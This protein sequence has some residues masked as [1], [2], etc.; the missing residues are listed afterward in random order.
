MCADDG[1]HQGVAEDVHDQVVWPVH[2]VGA[3]HVLPMQATPANRGSSEGPTHAPVATTKKAQQQAGDHEEGTPGAEQRQR[4]VRAVIAPQIHRRQERKYRGSHFARDVS[5][6]GS[7]VNPS[8][9]STS[10]YTL[11]DRSR[12]AARPRSKPTEPQDNEVVRSTKPQSSGRDP[13]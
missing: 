5:W 13:T 4:K 1:K 7:R 12:K 11:F 10:R 8:E 2:G 3:A 6:K 9:N